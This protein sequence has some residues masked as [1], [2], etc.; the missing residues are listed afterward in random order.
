MCRLTFSD[1]ATKAPSAGVA[2]CFFNGA[3]KT[4]YPEDPLR[5]NNV[6][7]SAF[8][9]G[10]EE[11]AIERRFNRVDARNVVHERLRL[12]TCRTVYGSWALRRVPYGLDQPQTVGA[13]WGP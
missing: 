12:I 3:G 9:V 1:V 13:D 2:F 8:D 11:V 5:F 7:T 10:S 6:D 4:V